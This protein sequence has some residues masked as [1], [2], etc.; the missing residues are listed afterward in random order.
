MSSAFAR[1]R[2][3]WLSALCIAAV[4]IF[5]AAK[6]IR[7]IQLASAQVTAAPFTL[8][9]VMRKPGDNGSMTVY[10]YKVS[11]RR[12]DGSTAQ[13][14][15][16]GPLSGGQTARRV[17]FLD[18]RSLSL[19]DALRLRSTWPMRRPEEVAA[20]RARLSEPP[21]NC[22]PPIE[23]GNTTLLGTENLN[24]ENVAVIQSSE[25]GYRLTRWVA[26]RLG[27]EPLQYR[28]E[29]LS[30]DGAATLTVEAKAVSLVL[31]EPDPRLFDVGSDY[32]ETLPSIV[33]SR[34]VTQAG[35][36]ESQELK[37]SGRILDE[38]YR[39]GR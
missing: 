4:A 32:E 20:L 3:Y 29:K 7:I 23:S 16:V 10:R 27:C 18:G 17:T 28:S 39:K 21:A 15:T 25:G 9:L 34:S 38:H 22:M 30:Q 19:V 26:P 6:H 11:A 31:A 12:S 1:E 8:Q 24:G 35:L 36:E 13:V 33:Q 5:Y 14:E 37:D 2:V